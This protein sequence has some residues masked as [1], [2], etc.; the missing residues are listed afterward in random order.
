MDNIHNICTEIKSVTSA[1]DFCKYTLG[2]NISHP[3]QAIC[4][5][6]F[7]RNDDSSPSF[8]IYHSGAYDF[9]RS[10]SYDVIDLCSLALFNGDKKSAIEYLYGKP[11]FSQNNI[12]EIS[13]A[14]KEFD[15]KVHYWHDT[16]KS[17][18]E[19][20][21]YL[22]HRHISDE[23]IEKFCLGYSEKRQR[24]IFPY[25]KNGHYVFWNG[26]DMSGGC[27]KPK[28]D[29]AYRSKYQKC[30][31]DSSSACEPIL[32]GLDTLQPRRKS[33]ITYEGTDGQQYD[34]HKKDPRDYTLVVVEGMVDALTFAQENWQVLSPGGGNI[35]HSQ[36]P[37]FVDLAR[38]YRQVML[39]FDNDTAGKNFTLS[40]SRALLEK[41]IPFICAHVPSNLNGQSIKDVSDYYCAGGDLAELEDNATPGL[42]ELASLCRKPHE[43]EELFMKA[44]RNYSKVQLFELKD[45]CA[46][47]TYFPKKFINFMFMQACAPMAEPDVAKIVN[48]QHTL[49][50]DDTGIFYEYT[51]GAWR[52][53]SD[54]IIQRYV[55][56]ALGMKAS[57]AK[58]KAVTN[59]L[60]AEHAGHYAFNSKPRMVFMNGTLHLKEVVKPFRAHT[61]EDMSTIQLGYN[62]SPSA[63]CTKWQKYIHDISGGD[64]SKMKLLQQIA[65]YVLCMDNRYQ[66]MFCLLGDGANGKSVFMNTLQQIYGPE[67]CTSLQPS[68][69][70]NDF[71]PIV[72]KNSLL[73]FCFETKATM[74]GADEALKAVISGDPIMAAHKGVDAVKFKTRAKFIIAMNKM[75]SA[76]DVSYGFLRRLVFVKFERIF[77]GENA[78]K[79]LERELLQELPGIFNWCYEGYKSL[80]EADGFEWT[81]EQ[82]DALDEFYEQSGTV[83]FAC[84]TFG[85]VDE[86][87][88]SE[89]DMY[90]KY[91][92][93]AHDSGYKT[94]NRSEFM[95]DMNLI[96][97]LRFPDV[98]IRTSENGVSKEFIFPEI[99]DD[100]DTSRPS[101]SECTTDESILA[102]ESA[103]ANDESAR[104][105]ADA[106]KG[107]MNVAEGTVHGVNEEVSNMVPEYSADEC[108]A[109]ESINASGKS[110][111]LEGN[112]EPAPEHTEGTPDKENAQEVTS[113]CPSVEE[114]N[115][116]DVPVISCGLSDIKLREWKVQIAADNAQVRIPGDDFSP[117]YELDGSLRRKVNP[118]R[119]PLDIYKDEATALAESV[120]STLAASYMRG[121]RKGFS[122]LDW[123]TLGL[124]C[125]RHPKSAEPLYRLG[126][127]RDL[128]ARG[129]IEDD[130]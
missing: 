12:Q 15:Q 9:A 74:N 109:E 125:K 79:N 66:K 82:A 42:V 35:S 45:A 117:Q 57:S 76:D 6:S 77:A 95:K 49:L 38:M 44:S 53:V 37:R 94:L 71:D 21:D 41:G 122:M 90:S 19:I 54:Y 123:Q 93:W 112:T 29:P 124:Y 96:I 8:A 62:Y 60:K 61:P 52:E 116:C 55:G 110:A 80:M 104:P 3:G 2:L 111:G 89:R 114:T 48:D 11:I 92:M 32:W 16:L 18:Q 46:E 84:E 70:G 4:A 20:I 101:E 75:F 106:K 13:D 78:N 59:Y 83:K 113:E 98:K 73:N 99:I 24:L 108:R 121:F 129:I 58:M 65:G 56:E 10:Q 30:K 63:K 100:D 50:F 47:V 88:I 118:R 103:C 72:L 107:D 39:C 25:A 17:H 126:L 119:N 14:Q 36:M 33:Q 5:P 105:S 127:E 81:Q 120:G 31:I 68:K 130:D 26:R 115:A 87:I 28:N 67:N 51:M 7:I 34:T 40:L 91:R 43:L 27:N 85:E 86:E 102:S 64:P 128:L 22:H 1:F 23:A 97:R 69:L